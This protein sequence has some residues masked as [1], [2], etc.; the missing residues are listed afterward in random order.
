MKKPNV[1]IIVA[2]QWRYDCFGF[3]GS[4]VKTPNLDA[5]SADSFNFRYSY[6]PLPSCCPARMAMLTGLTP[7]RL[8]ALWNY[9]I[10]LPIPS[11]TPETF[12]Y[13]KALSQ[14]GYS[15]AYIGKWHTSQ[16]YGPV[17]FGYGE[18]ISDGEYDRYRAK[19]GIAPIPRKS[20]FAVFDGAIDPAPL[21]NTRT[22][23]TAARAIE[24]INEL[25]EPWHIRMDFNEPHL[26]C[27]PAY[28]FSEMYGPG[29]ISEWVNFR[30]K[31]EN[32]PI[33]QR[34]QVENWKLADKKWDYWA[35]ILSRE[36]GI[37]SQ[38]DD[39][40]GEV[41]G[42]LKEKGLYDDTVII[43]TTDHGDMCGSHRMID[44]H[45]V[46]YEEIVRTPLLIKA[47]KK[48]KTD[49]FVNNCLDLA[50]TVLDLCGIKTD[51]SFDGV[52]L[53]PYL[54]GNRQDFLS[55]KRPGYLQSKQPDF[56]R[57]K[58]AEQSN[59][60]GK[61]PLKKRRYALSTFNGQQFG[62]YTIRMIRDKK[63]KY[64]FNT[65]DVD[66][67][68]DMKNDPDE[69]TNLCGKPGYEKIIKKYRKAMYEEFSALGDSLFKSMWIREQLTGE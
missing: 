55:G 39:A 46:L 14:N 25:N 47:G 65:G 16:N 61:Q 4:K 11:L 22:H 33:M 42:A 38:T 63:Y 19:Q 17:D 21:E 57:A 59:L 8:G 7:E 5:L 58:Q 26:P 23:W 12:T 37:M 51:A 62:L 1:L 53:Y 20:G 60:Q 48:G 29:D 41:I 52:S 2:D 35:D 45:Y 69:L 68:Y 27:D 10:C 43:F 6:T 30:E 54:Q 3:T 50:P 44:K 9:D 34:R 56:L 67:L 24:K 13:S 40:I 31:F 15:S 66:E 36:F 28:P 64:I 49:D 32:K 18:Y